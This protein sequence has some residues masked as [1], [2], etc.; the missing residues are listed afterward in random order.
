MLRKIPITNLAIILATAIFFFACKDDRS[1]GGNNLPDE[2][3]IDSNEMVELI[4]DTTLYDGCGCLEEKKIGVKIYQPPG[5]PPTKEIKVWFTFDTNCPSKIPSKIPGIAPDILHYS[6]EPFDDI[7]KK[8]LDSIGYPY[9]DCPQ[10]GLELNNRYEQH[11]ICNF[12]VDKFSNLKPFA[13]EAIISGIEYK[14]AWTYQGI[15]VIGP[16]RT[17]YD[18]F[19]TSFKI[20]RKYLWRK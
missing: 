8:I 1:I 4:T 13:C 9:L 6:T 17:H 19:I 2:P 18:F 15:D 12:P 5:E 10:A 7:F 16:A 20:Q 3:Q 11:H 14:P